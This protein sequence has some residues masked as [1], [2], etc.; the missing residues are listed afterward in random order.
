MSKSPRRRPPG[1]TYGKQKQ[2]LTL[3]GQWVEA[4]NRICRINQAMIASRIGIDKS[5]LSRATRGQVELSRDTVLKML[6]VYDEIVSKEHIMLPEHWQQGFFI[7]WSNDELLTEKTRMRELL[8]DI[9]E[10][11]VRR[12]GM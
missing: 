12:D 8:H 3:F 11:I 7:A 10:E 6:H 2:N 5:I 1:K 9:I 4:L